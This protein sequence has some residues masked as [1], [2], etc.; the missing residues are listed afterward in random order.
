M[1]HE[2]FVS[3]KNAGFT[4]F[5]ACMICAGIVMNNGGST[6]EGAGG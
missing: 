5:Q 1:L 2:M 6:N 3:L 4:D